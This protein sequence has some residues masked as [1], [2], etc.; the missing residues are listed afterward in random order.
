MADE[1]T[2]DA[3]GLLGATGQYDRKLALDFLGISMEGKYQGKGRLSAYVAESELET[4]VSQALKWSEEIQEICK[5][6]SHREYLK[7]NPFYLLDIL[8]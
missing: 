5:N 8:F 2:A 4:A 6:S 3:V 1:V 7:E